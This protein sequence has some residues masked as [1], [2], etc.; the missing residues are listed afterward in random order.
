MIGTIPV[1]YFDPYSVSFF[2]PENVAYLPLQLHVFK[3]TPEIF[4]FM[5]ANI[6]NPD[7]TALKEVV[8]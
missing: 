1:K 7:Q 3:C 5:E 2:L 4:S 6:M 8:S